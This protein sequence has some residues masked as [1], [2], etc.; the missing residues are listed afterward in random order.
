MKLV[1]RVWLAGLVGLCSS[2]VFAEGDESS[3][4]YAGKEPQQHVEQ[5]VKDGIAWVK[6]EYDEHEAEGLFKKYPP[7][8]QL[9]LAMLS[10]AQELQAK[11]EQA[12]A[13]GRLDQAQA[14]YFS[15]EASLNYAARMPHLLEQRNKVASGN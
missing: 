15:A 12:K 7:D 4:S 6:A 11:A 10:V 13:A 9:I 1:A 8:G 2:L 3:F 5:T 14:Y